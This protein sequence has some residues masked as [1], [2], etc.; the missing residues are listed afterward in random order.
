MRAEPDEHRARGSGLKLT[1]EEKQEIRELAR[2]TVIRDEFRLLRECSRNME[3]VD[4]DKFIAFLTTMAQLNPR[5]APQRP[6]IPYR[7]VKL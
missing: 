4:V 2:S 3:Q 7:S 5:F 1:E 6:F